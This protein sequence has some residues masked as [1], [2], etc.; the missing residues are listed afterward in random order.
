M[1]WCVRADTPEMQEVDAAT[2][3]RSWTIVDEPGAT[4]SAGDISIPLAAGEISAATHG[5]QTLGAL[6]LGMATA[7]SSSE[8]DCTLF[9]SVGVAV[10]DVATGAAAVAKATEMGLGAQASM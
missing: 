6:L 3:K 4:L 10:Q 1:R 5:L 9:K 7:P 8:V 2:M